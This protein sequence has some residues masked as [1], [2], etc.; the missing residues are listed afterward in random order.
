MDGPELLGKWLE[1]TG[2][3][4][5]KCAA[6]MGV[7]SPAV[8]AWKAGKY[9]PE[10]VERAKLQRLSNGDVP[11]SSWLSDEERQEIEGMLPFAHDEAA[12]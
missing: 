5:A 11:E 1:K 7:S 6:L 8:Q 4:F 3:S 10:I 2:I 12:A 9:R